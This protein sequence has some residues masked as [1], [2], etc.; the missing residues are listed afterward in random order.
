MKWVPL[1]GDGQAWGLAELGGGGMVREGGQQ[2]GGCICSFNPE[3]DCQALGLI[4]KSKP[5]GGK[6]ELSY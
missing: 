4:R 5:A 6:K 3:L 1:W 2:V